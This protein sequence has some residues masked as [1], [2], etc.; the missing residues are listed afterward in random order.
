MD[1][2]KVKVFFN[3]IKNTNKTKFLFISFFI[4]IAFIFSEDV[5]R[6]QPSKKKHLAFK[7]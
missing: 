7:D 5:I 2:N 3:K 4:D 6:I 1:F